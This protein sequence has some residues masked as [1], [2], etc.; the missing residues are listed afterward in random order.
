MVLTIARNLLGDNV[1][2]LKSEASK[3]AYQGV[4]IAVAAIIIA[5]FMV[6]FFSA[7]ELSLNGIMAA[8]KNNVALWV[9]DC[10]PFVFGFWGQYSSTLIATRPAP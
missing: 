2:I 7:G 8:Q 6:S 1:K 9:L 3:T 5:T 10:I 4:L